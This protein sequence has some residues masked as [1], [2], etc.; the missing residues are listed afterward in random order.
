MSQSG[1]KQNVR[2]YLTTTVSADPAGEATKEKT[3][4][5]HSGSAFEASLEKVEK[6]DDLGD[7]IELF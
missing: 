4:E 5:E 7:N 6:E 1:L 2:F 3:T